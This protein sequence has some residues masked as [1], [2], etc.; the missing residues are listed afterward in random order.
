M[1]R[2]T[3]KEKEEKKDEKKFLRAGTRTGRPIKGSIRGPHGPKKVHLPK[4]YLVAV[5]A[6]TSYGH[7]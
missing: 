5:V 1:N 2:E 3:E 7:M 6:N 4:K